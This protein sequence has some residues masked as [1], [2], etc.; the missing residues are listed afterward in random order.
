M[1]GGHHD[2]PS[3]GDGSFISHLK[4]AGYRQ[5]LTATSRMTS[6]CPSSFVLYLYPLRYPTALTDSNRNARRVATWKLRVAR[7]GSSACRHP[8]RRTILELLCLEGKRKDQT[9]FERVTY[10]TAAGCST[11][12]LLVLEGLWFDKGGSWSSG[13]DWSGLG[14]VQG[15]CFDSAV[16]LGQSVDI[17]SP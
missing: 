2:F 11:P 17:R 15:V 1:V 10:R 8:P 12:E 4:V 9:R 3:V 7:A 16:Q 6:Q 13:L 14:R 5:V